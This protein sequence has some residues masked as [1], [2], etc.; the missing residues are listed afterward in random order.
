MKGL[1]QLQTQFYLMLQYHELLYELFMQQLKGPGGM[2][3]Q[4][5]LDTWIL[6]LRPFLDQICHQLM[7][8]VFMTCVVGGNLS[9]GAAMKYSYIIGWQKKSSAQQVGCL[10]LL[11]RFNFH[12][13]API[14]MS[15]THSVHNN[16]K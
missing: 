4:E 11:S 7:Q 5:I 9:N 15:Y 14:R 2:P 6:P 8:A 1:H 10:C 13:L 12:Q 3:L 16:S